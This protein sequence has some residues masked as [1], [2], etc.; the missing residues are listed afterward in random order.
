MKN[1]LSPNLG[2]VSAIIAYILWGIFPLYWKLL[3]SFP[4]A[5]I[6]CHRIIWSGVFLSFIVFFTYRR[7][8]VLGYIKSP[9]I[10][11]SLTAGGLLIGANWFIY[12]WAINHEYVIE[13]SLGYYICPLLSI[14]L[15]LIFLKEKLTKLQWFSVILAFSAVVLLALSYGRFPWIALG[16]AS[17]FSFYGLLKKKSKFEALNCLWIEMCILFLPA[18]LFLHLKS[19]VLGYLDLNISA[20]I[21]L[22]GTGIVTFVPLLLFGYA[23]KTVKLSTLGF[24]QYIG[25]TGQFLIAVLVFKEEFTRPY[26]YTFVVIWIALVIF[27]LDGAVK[28]FGDRRVKTFPEIT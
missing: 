1:K 21:L 12:I 17:T 18:L 22:I 9:K 23:A 6:L 2:L 27:T 7:K 16:L 26:F 5:E 24:L 14:F 8:Q 20:I 25:P 13:A 3:S 28:K 19:N 4:A 10:L 15:G 11:V